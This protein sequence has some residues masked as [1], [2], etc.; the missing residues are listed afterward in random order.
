MKTRRIFPVRKNLDDQKEDA[1]IF[2]LVVG[3]HN[4]WLWNKRGVKK[5]DRFHLNH[6]RQMCP[7]MQTRLLKQSLYGSKKSLLI[8]KK[9]APAARK[10]K[11]SATTSEVV[12][13][14]Q[15]FSCGGAQTPV[16]FIK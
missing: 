11:V 5:V 7:R 12:S 13:E 9:A 1:N 4:N 10:S 14:T 6:F 2:F 8:D 15:R 16:G 3:F